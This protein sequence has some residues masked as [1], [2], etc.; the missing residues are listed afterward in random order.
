ML[1]LEEIRRKKEEYRF[2]NKQLSKLSGVPLGTLQKVLGNVTKSP[3]YETLQ[4]LSSVFEEKKK[5]RD[6]SGSVFLGDGSETSELLVAAEPEAARYYGVNNLILARNTNNYERQGTYTLEDYLAFPEEQ[7]VE[8][9]DGVIYDMGA[10]TSVHQ[11]ITGEVFR[12][13]SNYIHEKKVPCIPFSAPTDVQLN[14]DNRTIVQPDLLIVCDRSKINRNR[15]FGAP[16]F[17]LEVLSPSTKNKDIFIKSTKYMEAG[18]KEYWIV[19]PMKKTI[20]TYDFRTPEDALIRM[21]TFEDKV[22]MA[23]S[24]GEL[25]IDFSEIAEYISFVED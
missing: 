13:V 11:M 4:A 2:T 9:I 17:V 6:V 7:R 8:L 18:V 15:V 24:E 16:D 14:C 23:L 3:R 1:T 19:D 21:Y 5:R 10:P 20:M 25:V 12:Q 22:A